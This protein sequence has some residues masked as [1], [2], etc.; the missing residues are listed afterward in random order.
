MSGLKV[1]LG[2]LK[3]PGT[4]EGGAK[5]EKKAAP[6]LT[7]REHKAELL[8][9]LE[10]PAPKGGDRKEGGKRVLES[11]SESESETSSSSESEDERPKKA[12]EAGL[13]RQGAGGAKNRSAE[14]GKGQKVLTKQPSDI[15]KQKVLTKQP[16]D[17]GKQ[18]VLIKQPSDIGKQK[19]LIKQP[20]DIGSQRLLTK[21]PSDVGKPKV[22]DSSSGKALLAK[23][24]LLTKVDSFKERGAS[25]PGLGRQDSGERPKKVEEQKQNSLKRPEVKKVEIPK[26][27]DDFLGGILS[28]MTSTFK[29]KATL[30][31]E[32]DEAYRATK[33]K[34]ADP[35]FTY[36]QESPLRT[37]RV[38]SSPVI[39]SRH[40]WLGCCLSPSL[41]GDCPLLLHPFARPCSVSF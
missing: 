24:G 38:S 26:P 33:I 16:S 40:W 11:A 25:G 17:I 6:R 21:Q 5:K 29:P 22:G 14:G 8:R 2:L 9:S 28:G 7:E 37:V 41:Q 32:N 31:E 34:W 30:Y 15:G 23:K 12:A 10:A 1:K 35:L 36:F 3:K 39:W 27:E 18:K 13:A 20:P 4:G 19:V